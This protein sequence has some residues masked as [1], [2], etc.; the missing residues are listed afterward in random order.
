MEDIK[1]LSFVLERLCWGLAAIS[2][3]T[4]LSGEFPAYGVVIGFWGVFCAFHK[5]GRALF[6]F[7]TFTFLSCI[8][9]IVFMATSKGGQSSLYLFCV[10]MLILGLLLKLPILW[11]S[12][13]LFSSLGGAEV[14]HRELLDKS[15]SYTQSPQRADGFEYA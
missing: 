6:G 10:I 1:R 2:M 7:I 4:Q 9:E 14:I 11:V 15:G 3:N 12:S 13:Q 8:L 5:Y